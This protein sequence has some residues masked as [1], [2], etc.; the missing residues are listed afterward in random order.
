MNRLDAADRGVQAEL[1]QA[2]KQLREKLVDET[3]ELKGGAKRLAERL[4]AN[5][6]AKERALTER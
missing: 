2:D 1:Y 6:Q 5:L 4:E 3:A